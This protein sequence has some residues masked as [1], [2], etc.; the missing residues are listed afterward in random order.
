MTARLG[1]G[2]FDRPLLRRRTGGDHAQILV[3]RITIR[4]DS[5]VDF[6]NLAKSLSETISAFG[7]GVGDNHLQPS[8]EKSGRI[9]TATMPAE[10][11]AK[12]ETHQLGICCCLNSATL[13][14]AS[15]RPGQQGPAR[16]T[17]FPLRHRR[18][19]PAVH[20]KS[21]FRCKNSLHCAEPVRKVYG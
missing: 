8:V 11:T 16:L 5:I 7:P 12:Y 19:L 17:G 9:G 21:D 1:L 3:V 20:G 10:V 6:A 14:P 18:F 15:N 4:R 13:S 2:E